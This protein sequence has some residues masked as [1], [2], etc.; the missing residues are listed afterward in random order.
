MLFGIYSLCMVIVAFVNDDV[1][2]S[3]AVFVG[4]YFFKT[5]DVCHIHLNIDLH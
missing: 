1:G 5:L 3:V 2:V 4:V